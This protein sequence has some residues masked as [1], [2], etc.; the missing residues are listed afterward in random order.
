MPFTKIEQ[1][2]LYKCND[3]DSDMGQG[4]D[5]WGGGGNLKPTRLSGYDATGLLRSAPGVES[6]SGC[7]GSLRQKDGSE[8]R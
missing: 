7:L 2:P 5:M 3:A 8:S 6:G 4:I 1:D